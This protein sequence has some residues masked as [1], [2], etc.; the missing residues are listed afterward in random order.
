M[1]GLDHRPIKIGFKKKIGGERKGKGGS[2]K[3]SETTKRRN[4]A[5]RGG[6]ATTRG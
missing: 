4:G 1:G 2:K 3:N 5:M 6:I